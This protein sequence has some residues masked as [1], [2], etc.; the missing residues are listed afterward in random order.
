MQGNI[1]GQNNSNSNSNLGING[2]IEEY[3]VASGGNVNAGDFVKFI[4]N[5][6]VNEDTKL[7]TTSGTGSTISA[8][9]LTDNKVFIAH[10]YSSSYLYGMIV[11]I[12]EDNSITVGTDTSLSTTYG[13]G[14][15]I[16]AIQLTDNK[17]FIAH[18]CSDDF[19]LYGMI[20]TINEGNSITVGTDTSLRAAS[21]IGR[22]ISAIQLT[23]NKVFIAHSYS[24]NHYLYGMI[25]TINEGNSITVGTNT[26]LSTTE[27]SGREISAIQ[28]TDNKVFI[29]HSYSSDDFS[30]YG[31]IVTI[32]EDN[33]IN[34]GTDTSLS[35]T[36]GT[37]ST[38]S[39]IQLTDNKVFIAHSYSS[40]HYLYGISLDNLLTID[41]ASNKFANIL[42][43][44]N[45][46]GTEGQT[47]QVYVPSI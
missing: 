45:T 41:K 21:G 39:A 7:S 27:Y 10:S 47:V 36:S 44:S 29:A 33:S 32:N 9:Q 26:L 43:V 38:I 42:G 28:L 16:S 35:T 22:K 37:G 11:T 17:V 25:V 5:F 14:R 1:L 46:S 3:T 40:N 23:D 31:M 8:I 19:S 34:V 6:T 12:N 18:R 20:V 13:T 15:E 4:N 24:S 2:I 30:L